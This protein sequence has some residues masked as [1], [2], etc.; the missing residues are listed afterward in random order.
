[1]EKSSDYLVRAT[2][3]DAQIRAF[4]VT[5]RDIA[6]SARKAHNT[7]PVAT[8][9]LGRLLTGGVIMGSM[10]KGDRDT[11]TLQVRGDG[12]L[13]GMVVTADSA[14]HVKGYVYEPNV[15]IHA[16]SDGKLD[17]AGAVGKG[18]L[19][20]IKDMGLKEPYQGSC[21]LQTGEI[22][23]DLNYYF[24]VSEQVPS[25]TGLG[26]LMERDNTVKCAGGFVLQLLPFTPDDVI[27]KLEQILADLPPVTSMLNGGML[28]E[29]ILQRIL[30]DLE[31]EITDRHP[32]CWQCDCSK[33]R[34][35][36]ALISIGRKEIDDMIRDGKPVDVSCQFC[37]RQYHF[38]LEELK[39]L[40]SRI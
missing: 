26:V 16:R 3:A 2:A 35:E 25:A 10:L 12:P 19:T 15:L 29:D 8:A 40:K 32:V 4:A 33:N 11:L 1:M 34:V 20:V 6:E 38:D 31:P 7:S 36:R 28:P 22:A 30:G 5:S 27:T 17:V 23:E 13:R 39:A 9:A 14:G 18:T 37:G 24:T 21:R